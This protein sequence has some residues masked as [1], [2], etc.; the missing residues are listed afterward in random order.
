MTQE[1][2]NTRVLKILQ[3][4]AHNAGAD[5]ADMWIKRLKKDAEAAGLAKPEAK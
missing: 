3:N 5:N 4:L 1:E 2:F